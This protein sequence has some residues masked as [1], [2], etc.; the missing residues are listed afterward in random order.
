MKARGKTGKTGNGRGN[1]EV[2]NGKGSRFNVLN[3]VDEML[4]EKDD[5]SRC[6]DRHT[7][8]TGKCYPKKKDRLFKKNKSDGV[9]AMYRTKPHQA[10]PLVQM[11]IILLDLLM[12]SYEIKKSLLKRPSPCSDINDDNQPLTFNFGALKM[13]FIMAQI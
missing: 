5:N 7:F 13:M 12:I 9:R 10:T 4:N 3:M 8:D 2:R 6:T 11:I 1:N